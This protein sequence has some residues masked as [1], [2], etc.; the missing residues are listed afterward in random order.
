MTP[1]V[2]SELKQLESALGHDLNNY[3]QLV[4]GNLELLKRRK[5]YAP[6]IVEA[7]LA[8][9][10][11]AADLADRMVA[12]GKLQPCTPRVVR[13]NG[14]L[15]ELREMIE[16][17]VGETI[18]VDLELGAE[19]KGIFVDPHALHVML[20]ELVGNARAAM[21]G[22]GKLTVRTANAEHGFV[23]VEIADTGSGMAPQILQQAFEPLDRAEGSK[24]PGLG[25][26]IVQ[27]CIRE[28]GGRVEIDSAPG[29]GTRVKLYLQAR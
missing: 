14:A 13:L 5:E 6:Q 22:G 8:A 24:P 25:L 17:S 4:M 21:A 15:E 16:R 10:R 23:R 19:V 26:L 20:L 9:T 28:A 12:I 11:T 29:A 3:L 27:Y 2:T 1:A 7:A 18:R